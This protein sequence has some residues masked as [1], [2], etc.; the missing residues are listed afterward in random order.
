MCTFTVMVCINLP[1]LRGIN[2][3]RLVPVVIHNLIRRHGLR[4]KTRKKVIG[5]RLLFIG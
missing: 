5:Y 1:S 2:G 3:R 4:V